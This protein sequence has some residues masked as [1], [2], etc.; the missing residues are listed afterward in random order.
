MV[1]IADEATKSSRVDGPEFD[2]EHPHRASFY[3]ASNRKSTGEA[4]ALV[5]SWVCCSGGIL[6]MKCWQRVFLRLERHGSLFP[7]LGRQIPGNTN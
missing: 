4:V 3:F 6:L 5:G 2:V 1:A 7:T